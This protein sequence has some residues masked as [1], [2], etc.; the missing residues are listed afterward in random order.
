MLIIIITLMNLLIVC[1]IKHFYRNKH[2]VVVVEEIG[3]HKES[4]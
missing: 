1:N 4:L 3:I 2:I